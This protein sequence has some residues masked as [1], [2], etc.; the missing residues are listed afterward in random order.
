MN[1]NT[2]WA[3]Y[4]TAAWDYGSVVTN[5]AAVLPRSAE[6]ARLRSLSVH[7]LIKRGVDVTV[8]ALGIALTLPLWAVIA[9]AVK[10]TSRGP[11]LFT[12]ERAGLNGRPFRMFK[13]RTMVADAE[14]RLKDLVRIEDLAEPVFKLKDD[15][16][17]T[18]VGRFLRRFGLDELPQ[19]INVL[20]GEMSLVGPRPEVVALA[21]RYNAEQRRRLLVKPGITGWQQVH[22]RGMPDMGARLAYDVYYL[23]NRSVPLDFCILAMTVFVIASGRE[24][25]Y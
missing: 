7:E 17:V 22:N 5:E 13:F 11:V 16:R 15:P 19:L 4:A 14:E 18:R 10:V 3:G 12:Q 8:A 2:A 23:R 6:T 20:R 24:I 25:T 9:L 21:E 1:G